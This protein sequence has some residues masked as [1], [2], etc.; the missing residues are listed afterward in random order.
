MGVEQPPAPRRSDVVRDETVPHVQPRVHA[1]V[2]DAARDTRDTVSLVADDLRAHERELVG[3]VNGC[4]LCL[5]AVG[6]KD[7]VVDPHRTVCAQGTALVSLKH[8]FVQLS[9]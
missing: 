2:L 9:R 6:A 5:N 4:A 7:A 8:A 3:V 1:R